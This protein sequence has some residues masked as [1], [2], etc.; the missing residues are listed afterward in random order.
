MHAPTTLLKLSIINV[1]PGMIAATFEKFFLFP[2]FVIYRQDIYL[3]G[4]CLLWI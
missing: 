4:F 1:Q 3:L 2:C